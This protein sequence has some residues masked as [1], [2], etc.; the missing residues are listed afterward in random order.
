MPVSRVAGFFQHEGRH[1]YGSLYLPEV[2]E[3]VQVGLV[4]C[5][6]FADEA[7][8]A[9]RVLVDFAVRLAGKGMPALLFDY[10]GT[11]DSEGRFEDGRRVEPGAQGVGGVPVPRLSRSVSLA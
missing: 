7:V 5:P 10:A 2:T 8:H 11:G 1:L 4:L 9:H 3:P 6:P